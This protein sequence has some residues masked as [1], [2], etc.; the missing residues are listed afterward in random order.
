MCV[1]VGA[2]WD[3]PTIL[4]VPTG[5]RLLL[6]SVVLVL[7]LLLVEEVAPS[8]GKVGA[9][10]SPSAGWPPTWLLWWLDL[11][12]ILLMLS[13]LVLLWVSKFAG[14]SGTSSLLE[15]F[16]DA[17]VCFESFMIL[18]HVFVIPLIDFRFITT[19]LTFT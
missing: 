6:P 11:L 18:I 7:L 8:L 12:D 17:R 3:S 15:I 5:W 19:I 2:E 16:T 10:W 14:L 9:G 4:H 13:L 1:P